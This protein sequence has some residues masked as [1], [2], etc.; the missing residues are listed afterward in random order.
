M[1]VTVFGGSQPK[2]GDA[3]YLDDRGRFWFC[4]RVAHRVQTEHGT[5]YTDPVEI[6]AAATQAEVLPALARLR[7][8]RRRGL[9]PA[10]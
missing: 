5:L 3:G 8:A 2:E 1:N 10:C 4:G 9:R 7:G 6:V